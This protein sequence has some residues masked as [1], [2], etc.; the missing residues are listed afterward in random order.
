MKATRRGSAI[1]VPL[2]C[3]AQ[4]CK[5]KNHDGE[6]ATVYAGDIPKFGDIYGINF[7]DRVG[8]VVVGSVG[9]DASALFVETA[10]KEGID[11]RAWAAT[12]SGVTA[13]AWAAKNG[14]KVAAWGKKW[15]FNTA[16]WASKT[17]VGGTK[18]VA[19][20][21]FLDDDDNVTDNLVWCG[22]NCG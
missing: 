19:K 11:P 12:A 4:L 13:T 20:A 3:Y 2:G 21:V 9:D 7:N 14:A 5:G 10:I 15:G 8:S 18:K 22:Y 17:A 1:K 6:C 16:K